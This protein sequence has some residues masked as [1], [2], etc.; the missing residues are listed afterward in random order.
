MEV[1]FEW[2]TV[3]PNH[4]SWETRYAELKVFAVRLHSSIHESVLFWLSHMAYNS[5]LCDLDQEKYGHAQV[6]T[7]LLWSWFPKKR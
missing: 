1:G 3:N 5:T 6:S 2:S 7:A 4:V